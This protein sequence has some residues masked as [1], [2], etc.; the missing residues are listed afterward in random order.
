MAVFLLFSNEESAIEMLGG[1]LFLAIAISVCSIAY[2]VSR[3]QGDEK[4]ESIT[5]DDHRKIL[6]ALF[7]TFGVIKFLAAI[8]F[9]VVSD[10]MTGSDF[11]YILAG[12]ILYGVA[13]YSMIYT[14]PWS[15]KLCI[16]LSAVSLIFIPLGT[17]LGLYYFWFYIRHVQSLRS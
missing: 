15:F 5:L 1:W 17:V 9:S 7:I 13:G 8:Y 12:S 10:D 11:M 2:A 14:T 16:P 3:S 4:H 6:G